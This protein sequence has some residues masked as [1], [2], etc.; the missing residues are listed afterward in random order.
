[1]G[2]ALRRRLQQTRFESEH[3]EALLNLLVAAGSFRDAL[4]RAC[5]RHGVTRGQYNVLR[6][7]R[8]AHPEGYARCEIARRLVERAPDVTRLIDRLERQGLIERR[9]AE[10]DRRLSIAHVT[11]K[12][13]HLLDR[14]GPDIERVTERIASRLSEA[15]A[16][17]L[18]RLCEQL[19]Y[20]DE[21]PDAAP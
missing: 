2:E 21:P 18:S 10:R 7:L 1:M 17:E 15:E 16:V 9:D 5:Q 12:G 8:G 19:Y 3:H 11:R 20:D 13:L 6:I 4:D 14:M